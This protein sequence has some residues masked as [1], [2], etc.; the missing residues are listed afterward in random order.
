M[1]AG[2]YS[3]A[4]L[5]LAKQLRSG[6]PLV[7]PFCLCLQPGP[8]QRL[9]AQHQLAYAEQDLKVSY[10]QQQHLCSQARGVDLCGVLPSQVEICAVPGAAGAIKG[11]AGAS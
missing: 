6:E 3:R 5:E 11:S 9:G 10:L 1:S 8:G 4:R 2:G 7:L